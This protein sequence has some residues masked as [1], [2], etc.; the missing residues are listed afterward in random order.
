MKLF[1][2]WSGERSGL[3]A[4]GLRDWL[5]CVINAVEPWLS[6]NDLNP[7]TRWGMELANELEQTKY[8]IICMTAD[9]MSSPW[10]LFEAGAL[11]RYVSKSR[12]VPLLLDNKPSDL[13]GPLAQ[14]QAVQF[15]ENDIRRLIIGINLTIFASGERGLEENVLNESLKLWWP[16]LKSTFDS[17]PPL[18][19][20]DQPRERTDRELIEETLE[21]IRLMRTRLSSL[22]NEVRTT[23]R[24]IRY[25]EDLPSP[26]E[27]FPKGWDEEWQP[28]FEDAPFAAR[29]IQKEEIKKQAK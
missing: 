26:P 3:F 17:I 25:E 23:N 8:G 16:K 4:Q 6:S 15:S 22:T 21:H 28:S 1:I 9:N 12:V 19:K 2:S 10:L 13:Q 7:G 11:S 20:S 14:F 24:S 27:N 5:P 29:P 18:K